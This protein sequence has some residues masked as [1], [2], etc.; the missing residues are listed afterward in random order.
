MDASPKGAPQI[1]N[2]ENVG[3]GSEKKKT[4]S[5][6]TINNSELEG[7]KRERNLKCKVKRTIDLAPRLSGKQEEKRRR[8]RN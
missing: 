3:S 8:V 6:T 5:D 1:G 2:W 7:Q 4:G